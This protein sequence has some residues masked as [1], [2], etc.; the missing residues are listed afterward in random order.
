MSIVLRV[1]MFSLILIIDLKLH[2]IMGITT[3]KDK[4]LP[5]HGASFLLPQSPDLLAS[6]S[7]SPLCLYFQKQ[8]VD[9]TEALSIVSTVIECY[10]CMIVPNWVD[11]EMQP[12]TF[13]VNSNTLTAIH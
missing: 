1:K 12:F 7:P 8:T 11:E 13:H 2:I 4:R 3:L 5:Y 10:F 9:V 6:P